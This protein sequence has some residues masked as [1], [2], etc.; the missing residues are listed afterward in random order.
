MNIHHFKKKA[1]S[2]YFSDELFTA[3]SEC[4]SKDITACFVRDVKAAP[5]AISASH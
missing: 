2:G 1:A 5:D 3:L 4:I